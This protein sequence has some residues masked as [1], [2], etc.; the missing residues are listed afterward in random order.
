MWS[1]LNDDTQVLPGLTNELAWYASNGD[2]VS[3]LATITAGVLTTVVGVP[4]WATELSL[5][6]G[7]TNANLTASNGGIVYSTA[8]A[9]AILAGTATPNL[10]LLSQN[11]TA[12]IWGPYALSLGG[13][14]TTGGAVTFSGAHTFTG[15]LTGDTSVTFPT[16]GTLATTAQAAISFATD[17]GTAAPSSGTITISGGSTGLTTTGSGSTVALAGILGLGFGGTNHALTAS[18]GGIVYSDATKLDILAGTATAGLALLSGSSTAPVWSASAP[19]LVGSLGTGVQT[20][21]GINVGTAGSFVVNGGVLGTPSSGTLTNAIGLPLT[22]GVTGN[23]PVT[24]LNSGTSAS[25]STF[26]RG[27]GTWA[28]PA[29][30]GTV[31]S[32]LINQ[33]AYYASAGTTLSGL[34]IVNSA[35]LTTTA[36]GVPTWV[37]Y[38]GSG[39]P[40]L[41]TSPTLV[42]PALGTP[43]SGTLTNCIG[44]PLT[45]GV[46]GNLPVT[47]LNSG[48][49]A[50]SST[51]WRGDG[52]WAAPSG[53]GTVNSGTQYNLAY[54]ATTGTAVSGL[55]NAGSSGLALLSGSPPAWS[56][57]P[58]ITAINYQVFF[59][60]GSTQTYT[61]SA[62][63]IKAEVEMVGGG[64]GGA[65]STASSGQCGAGGGGAAGS[66]FLGLLTAA[67]IGSSQT[68]TIGAAGAAGSNSGGTGGT[69][70]TTSLGS[71]ILAPGGLG[72]TSISSSVNHGSAAG[73][74]GVAISTTTG[75]VIQNITGQA[76]GAGYIPGPSA[77]AEAIAG[78]GGSNP[79]GFGGAAG[80]TYTA[81]NPGTGYGAGGAGSCNNGGPYAGG[82]GTAGYMLIKE[83]I[84]I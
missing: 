28:A 29:N 79:L 11:A 66:Y 23:L 81:G 35:A 62:G 12:P 59:Y 64:G 8:S 13:A 1:Q 52:T 46:T 45:T 82:A 4:T 58:P 15:T 2:Q 33:L 50:S 83:Y 40:V 20:A 70:G 75:T 60:T 6:L 10:P 84:S 80:I 38:T 9:L 18:N 42:T 47:N 74:A 36:G 72:G 65:G 61:A 5:A 27:D 30:T 56:T 37:A 34:T 17:S 22:T 25:S 14:L 44:L 39:A 78:P 48:T 49:S 54:Y 26:W 53:S 73:G 41:A 24:N 77:A 71:L 7:G 19:L 16:S 43:S 67:Q 32:G 21:L 3:G 57:N 68:V 51:F 76:G 69:G 55:T 31:N 63:L